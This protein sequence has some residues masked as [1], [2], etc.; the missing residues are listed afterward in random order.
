MYAGRQQCPRARGRQDPPRL[1]LQW[2]SGPPGLHCSRRADGGRGGQ[3]RR[4]LGQARHV[5]SA[6]REAGPSV[7]RIS[8]D[9]ISSDRR[10]AQAPHAPSCALRAGHR[11]PSRVARSSAA[12]SRAAREAAPWFQEA[13]PAAP[14]DSWGA[15]LLLVVV[16]VRPEDV[17]AA[18]QAWPRRRRPPPPLCTRAA[19]GARS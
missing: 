10:V 7:A 18:R 1:P 14:R 11:C 2:P 3:W 19:T 16:R 12:P 4:R 8:S 17:W 5:P 15:C 6:V 9:R 13:W